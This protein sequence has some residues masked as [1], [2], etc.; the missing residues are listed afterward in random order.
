MEPLPPA[1]AHAFVDDLG[2]PALSVDDHHHLERV[3][4]LR[5]GQAVTVAD[6]RGRWRLC[7]WR[8]GGTLEVVGPE[9]DDVRPEPAVT[10]AFA[11]TKGDRPE[12]VVQKLTE[13]G[14]DTIVA[15]RAGRSVVR[16][17]DAK[18]AAQA[19]RWRR[20]A[21]EA[22]MQ[23][24]QARLPRVVEVVDFVELV[25]SVAGTGT[26]AAFGGDPPS[27]ERPALLVGPEGGWTPEEAACGL[28]ATSLGPTV[29]RAET[30][31]TAGASLLCALRHRLVRPANSARKERHTA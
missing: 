30:A 28:P 11:L 8:A 16:W 13:L 26:L 17:D 5:D 29:L 7:T 31:A 24:R 19:E 1:A 27:L 3:L 14:V 25:P 22:A 23:S 18:A 2:S 9:V 12:W 21:R 20:V 10:V 4:R 15:F 6:G